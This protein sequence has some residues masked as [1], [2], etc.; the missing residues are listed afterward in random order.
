MPQKAYSIK[1]P[2][3]KYT[4]KTMIGL[5]AFE[6]KKWYGKDTERLA[7]YLADRLQSLFLPCFTKC[8]FFTEINRCSLET[9]NIEYSVKLSS[10]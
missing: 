4:D 8:P 1:G 5:T 2:V 6:G 9:S 10:F 3:D 7:G